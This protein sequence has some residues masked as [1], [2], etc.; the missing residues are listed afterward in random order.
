MAETT[1]GMGGGAVPINRPSDVETVSGSAQELI[2]QAPAP[3]EEGGKVYRVLYPTDQ[4][5][6]EGHPVVTSSGTAL[7]SEQADKLLPVAEASGV[8]IVEVED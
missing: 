4:F 7:T 3:T 2:E 5:V 6:M 1:A 8:R